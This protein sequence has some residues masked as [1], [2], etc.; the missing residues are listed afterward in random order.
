M[1][2]IWDEWIL[3]LIFFFSPVVKENKWKRH[4]WL[5]SIAGYCLGK[6][7]VPGWSV[8]IEKNQFHQSFET[9]FLGPLG[10]RL[11]GWPSYSAGQ[12]ITFIR[13]EMSRQHEKWLLY[14][15]AHTPIQFP[16]N[17]F[18][19]SFTFLSA[20]A[21]AAAGQSCGHGGLWRLLWMTLCRHSC[22]TWRLGTTLAACWL[23]KVPPLRQN[24]CALKMLTGKRCPS[25]HN[26]SRQC[27][28]E[29]DISLS[30]LWLHH[31]E[32]HTQCSKSHI[33]VDLK[34]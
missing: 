17:H 13:T 34:T 6:K 9:L 18:W 12:L 10:A 14:I 21:A 11:Q 22:G 24:P 31:L 33:S 27:T 16:H 1:R 19:I 8:C 30:L 7:R 5:K 29:S 28:E 32:K 26:V 25:T 23:H 2:F 4:R 3:F 20:A 15:S